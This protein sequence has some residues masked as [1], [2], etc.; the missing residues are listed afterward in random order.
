MSSPTITILILLLSF[1]IY[2]IRDGQAAMS[3][4][5]APFCK[6]HKREQIIKQ[7]LPSWDANQTW[8]VFTLA[9]LYGGFPKLFGNLLSSHY[10]FFGVFLICLIV[11]GAAI[12]FYIKS[13][14]NKSAWLVLLSLASGLIILC[15]GMACCY[16]LSNGVITHDKAISTMGFIICFNLT[17]AYCYLFKVELWQRGGFVLSL[18]ITSS[19]L[20]NAFEVDVSTNAI[21]IAIL[22]I[23]IILVSAFLILALL[24]FLKPWYGK[25]LLHILFFTNGFLVIDAAF[26]WIFDIYSTWSLSVQTQ[27]HSIINVYSLILL[28]IIALML[29]WVK[30]VFDRD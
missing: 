4:V 7:L 11:R 27:H 15:H 14:E 17:A 21:N 1:S 3:C 6:D 30:K 18:I 25:A 16:V 8:L 12:E 10:E 22:L 19:I 20:F 5:F 9:G 2:L 26:P 28:P 23:R 29:G 24:R 13:N